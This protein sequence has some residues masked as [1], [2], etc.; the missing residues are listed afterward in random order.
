MKKDERRELF[1]EY[2][3]CFIHHI[4]CI[5]GVY[6]KELFEW[7]VK[8]SSTFYASKHPELTEYISKM[9]YSIKSFLEKNLV[10]TVSLVIRNH[11]NVIEKYVFVCKFETQ[12]NVE[13]D[14]IH[15]KMK[16]FFLKFNSIGGGLKKLSE[17]SE[18]ISFCLQICTNEIQSDF[19]PL[20]WSYIDND[21]EKKKKILPVKSMIHEKSGMKL[22]L[23]VQQFI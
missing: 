19:V 17:C 7:K 13:F 22:E 11:E 8:N 15:L 2:L 14:F 4:I 18:E 16:D 1:L 3:E 6:P 5:R 20:E 10:E 23:Y 9:L 21:K 12:K